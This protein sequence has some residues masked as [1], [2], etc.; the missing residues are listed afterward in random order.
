MNLNQTNTIGGLVK[1]ARK[2]QGISQMKLAAK[3]GVSYQQVQ[4]YENGKTRI[5]VTRL[6]QISN[7]LGISAHILLNAEPAISD[8][9]SMNLSGKELRLVML[10]RKL[11][12][13]KQ[14]NTFINILKDI[15]RLI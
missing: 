15:T 12:T 14:Q 1:I 2:T 5:T 7:T 13:D 3:L 6:A 9:A 10:F 4:K 11:K 8:S